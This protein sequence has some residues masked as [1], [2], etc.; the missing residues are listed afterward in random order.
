MQFFNKHLLKGIKLFT[1]GPMSVSP[2]IKKIM[3]YD[4][5]TRDTYFEIITKDIRHS[6]TKMAFRRNTDNYSCV[7]FP[8]SGTFGIESVLSGY[9]GG[10]V[11]N[12]TAALIFHQR[13]HKAREIKDAVEVGINRRLPCR[14]LDVFHRLLWAR[15]PCVVE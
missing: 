12:E 7:L 8:G 5:P 10:H 2:K 11:E 4:L 1:P 13:D 6:L 9:T 3:S 14:H 15:N